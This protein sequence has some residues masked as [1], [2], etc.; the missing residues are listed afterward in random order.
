VVG[1]CL[2]RGKT[3]LQVPR[4]SDHASLGCADRAVGLR[5]A[6]RFCWGPWRRGLKFRTLSCSLRASLC[7]KDDVSPRSFLWLC[8]EHYWLGSFS[9]FRTVEGKSLRVVTETMLSSQ[10]LLDPSTGSRPD[11]NTGHSMIMS[12][13]NDLL[14]TTFSKPKDIP[15][16]PD[17][18]PS[19]KLAVAPFASRL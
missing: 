17:P 6:W 5:A 18:G 7:K 2:S 4:T 14:T 12:S 1:G 8:I 13:L 15:L 19:R 11:I 16:I 3:S 9:L 10:Y